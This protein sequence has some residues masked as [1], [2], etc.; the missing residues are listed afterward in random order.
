MKLFVGAIVGPPNGVLPMRTDIAAAAVAQAHARGKPAFAHPT[1][2]RGVRIAL[3]AGVD[4]LTHCTAGDG[5]WSPE[6]VAELVRKRVALVPTL[7]L[8]EVELAKEN[9]PAAV[10]ERI[11]REGAQQ[12]A[13]FTRAGG[14]LLYGTDVGYVDE[15]DIDARE[16]RL[17]AQAG[18]DWRAI[19]ASLTTAPAT[20]FGFGTRK[21]RVERGYD[22][23][24]VVLDGDPAQDAG[25]LARVKMTLREGRVVYRR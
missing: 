24:L 20:R 6:L 12:V 16:I 3:A 22:A 13:A 1:I 11:A 14:T 23:D 4:V 17:L 18:L 9:A 10:R 7:A 8:F 2:E 15:A 19:L 25:A 5:P 21:G